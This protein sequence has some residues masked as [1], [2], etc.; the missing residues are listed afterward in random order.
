[1]T[2][3][4]CTSPSATPDQVAFETTVP[5]GWISTRCWWP[6]LLIFVKLPPAM[7]LPDPSVAKVFTV[8]FAIGVQV[9]TKLPLASNAARSETVSVAPLWLVAAVNLPPT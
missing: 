1:M 6:M 3:S 8:P 2:A 7:M 9:E 4:A 5:L